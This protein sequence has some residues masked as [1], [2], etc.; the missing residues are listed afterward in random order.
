[1]HELT[2]V[3][4][5]HYV[6][7]ARWALDRFGVDY[8][9]H[10]Y[11][12]MFH[13]A[14]VLRAHRGKV[15]ASDRV[16]SRYSTPVLRTPAGRCIC[17]SEEIVRYASQHFAPES[18]QLYG[19]HVDAAMLTR[20]HDVLGPHSRRFAYGAMFE[21][22][23]LL[24]S[25]AL[26]NVNRMQATAFA[27]LYPG[28]RSQIASL[29]GVDPRRLQRSRDRVLQEV[30]WL[31]SVLSD[32]RPYLAGDRFSAADLGM[33]CML[34]PG[35]LPPEYGAWLPELKAF[36]PHVQELVRE[37]RQR[38]AG[39]HAT[40]MFRQERRNVVTAGSAPN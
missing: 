3:A 2:S 28:V 15:G 4:F 14:G 39:Q 11:M 24:K 33:A 37:L 22:P 35:V 25:I 27:M 1:M 20:L 9:D 16:S 7:K 8:I 10:R 34:A 6:E 30:E 23:Q 17:D 21:R 13:F 18:Q 12:P 31:D 32:G 38:P 29:L 19:E 40:R 5:S 26:R 36:S